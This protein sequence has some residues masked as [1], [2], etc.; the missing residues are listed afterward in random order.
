MKRKHRNTSRLTN[1]ERARKVASRWVTT[2]WE[3]NELSRQ[4]QVAMAAAVRQALRRNDRR[5]WK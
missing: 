2:S 3:V 5:D 4:I 1:P